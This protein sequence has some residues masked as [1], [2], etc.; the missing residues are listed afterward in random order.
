MAHEF[1]L[2]PVHLVGNLWQ[3]GTTA[4]AFLDVYAV[5]VQLELVETLYAT[6][7]GEY[8]YLNIEVV[9]LIMRY[10]LK[11]WVFKGCSTSHLSHNLVQGNVLA[12]VSDTAT[13]STLLV[14]GNKSST[15]FFK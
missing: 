11:T 2:G 3:E 6:H 1:F 14:K 8:G 13:Q 5:F 15:L 7:G 4:I 10:R 12:K 9:E